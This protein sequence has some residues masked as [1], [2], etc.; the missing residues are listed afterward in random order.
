MTLHLPREIGAVVLLDPEEL[1]RTLVK[2]GVPRPQRGA[3]E[4]DHRAAEPESARSRPPGPMRRNASSCAAAAPQLVSLREV[5]STI[6]RA[7]LLPNRPPLA[8]E[9]GKEA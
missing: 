4:R 5:W 6:A 1:H 2:A 9:F 8:V 3:R 7:S